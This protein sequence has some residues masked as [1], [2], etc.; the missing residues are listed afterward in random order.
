M[1]ANKND[2]GNSSFFFDKSS[3]LKRTDPWGRV[4]GGGCFIEQ[5]KNEVS[6]YAIASF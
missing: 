5:K 1:I 3:V 4:L 6:G 2:D